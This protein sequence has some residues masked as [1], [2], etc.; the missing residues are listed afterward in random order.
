[1][2]SKKFNKRTLAFAFSYMKYLLLGLFLLIL[3][4]CAVAFAGRTAHASWEDRFAKPPADARILK[5]I[6]NWPDDP[7]AQ[8]N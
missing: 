7:A 4:L 8:D 2:I 1:M 3:G 5:I 6:H